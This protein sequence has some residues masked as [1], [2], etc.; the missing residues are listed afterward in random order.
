M[1][2]KEGLRELRC[3]PLSFQLFL[4]LPLRV[5]GSSKSRFKYLI[6]IMTEDLQIEQILY[7]ALDSSRAE[8]RLLVLPDS[9]TADN[10]SISAS[11]R[12][13]SLHESPEF[14]ALSYVWGSPTMTQP[15]YVDGSEVLISPNLEHIIRILL[16]H[17]KGPATVRG[18]A[19]WIDVFCI[20]QRN[21][22]EKEQ[23]ISLMGQIYRQ[24]TRVLMW[25]GDA[26]GHAD[27]AMKCM[28]DP[29]F[30][31]FA[32]N[33]DKTRKA[34]GADE[35]RLKLIVEEDLE[36]RAYWTR[37]W[38]GQELVLASNDPLVL[39]GRYY[40][41]WSHYVNFLQ[42]MPGHRVDYPEVRELWD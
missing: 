35:I 38:I 8:I 10:E 37:V 41:P 14:Y 3:L 20:D 29:D 24:A 7:R 27:W 40:V 13:I 36:G 23:Q 26:E 22:N 31:L 9:D 39:C 16:S 2:S 34:P 32:S 18:K 4:Q 11:F 1:K 42:W 25:L 21:I 30:Y 17:E 12:I 5:T 19:I 28:S 33:L 15:L 6:A